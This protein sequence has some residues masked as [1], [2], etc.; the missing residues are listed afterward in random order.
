MKVG[1]VWCGCGRWRYDAVGHGLDE[2]VAVHQA[3]VGDGS[4]SVSEQAVT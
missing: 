1:L 4:G 2:V 3:W